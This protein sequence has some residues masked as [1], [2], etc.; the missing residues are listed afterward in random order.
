M[1]H[2]SSCVPHLNTHTLAICRGEVNEWSRYQLRKKLVEMLEANDSLELRTP[3]EER[4]L[5][6]FDRWVTE[7]SGK[8]WPEQNSNQSFV[9][10][11]LSTGKSLVAVAWYGYDVYGFSS[12][13]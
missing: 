4:V 9:Y 13:F 12:S 2:F 8:H 11:N 7:L 3:S 5:D 10:V 6:D 1:R